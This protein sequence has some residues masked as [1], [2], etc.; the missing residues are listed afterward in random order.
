MSSTLASHHGR[1]GSDRR[2]RAIDTNAAIRQTTSKEL[3]DERA[4][5][6][7]ENVGMDLRHRSQ[8]SYLSTFQP[9]HGFHHER[10]RI[11]GLILRHHPPL[12]RQSCFRHDIDRLCPSAATSCCTPS[13]HR[14]G[15]TVTASAFGIDSGRQRADTISRPPNGCLERL[16]K[17]RGSRR[18]T[19]GFSG[20]PS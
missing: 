6:S 18:N 19:S 15:S 10:R 2:G 4:D 12:T 16:G 7:I 9:R 3:Q 20:G 1:A 8:P 14:A 13:G 17:S 11:A 5:R